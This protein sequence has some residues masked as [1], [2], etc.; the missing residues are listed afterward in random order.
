[1]RAYTLDTRSNP[2]DRT[3]VVPSAGSARW[4]VRSRSLLDQ[5]LA[6]S[7]RR[8]GFSPVT[9]HPLESGRLRLAI[10]EARSLTVATC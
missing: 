9:A 2:A 10:C 7:I 6:L 3:L 1:V 4:S 5:L 8:W